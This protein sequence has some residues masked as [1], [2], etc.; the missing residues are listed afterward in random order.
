[1][2]EPFPL[3]LPMLE[4]FS[5]SSDANELVLALKL[6]LGILLSVG[7]DALDKAPLDV[8]LSCLEARL[9]AYTK[10]MSSFSHMQNLLRRMR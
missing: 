10:Q 3:N 7:V 9:I 8:L 2:L 4:P 5:L 1:M 6:G